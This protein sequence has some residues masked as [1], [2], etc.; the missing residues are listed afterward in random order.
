MA[1]S[2]MPD[3]FYDVVSHHLPPDEQV[4]PSGGRP[5]VQNIIVL[6]VLWYVL[7]T[8]CR[9]RDVPIEMGCCGETARRRLERWEELGVWDRVHADMLR[10][11]RR[12]GKLEHET[13]IVDGVLVRAHGGGQATGP[14]PV[15]RRKK[16]T[17]YTVMVDKNGIPLGIRIA[18]ANVSDQRQ[19]LPLVVNQF[20]DVGG[21]PGRPRTKPEEVY[22][23]AGYDNDSTRAILN[24]L[25]MTPYIRRK[26]AQHGSGLGKVRWVVER[27]IGWIK[28]LRR[29]RIRY[30]RKAT[31]IE[32][33]ATL[34]I[35]VIN[36]RIWHHD[37]QLT[38]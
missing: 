27:S 3:E 2:R 31:I 34:A 28:G 6:R 36:F 18:G 19:V 7:T 10:L 30:D 12:D 15:D 38:N 37:I 25:G 33:W 14:S 8:G 16:G 22:A 21:K 13:A 29:L 4:G 5:P 23:D 32:G 9:W 1:D 20:P 35:S 17:K 24:W 11:L 26:Q